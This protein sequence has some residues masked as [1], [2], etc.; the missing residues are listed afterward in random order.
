MARSF[1][2]APVLLSEQIRNYDTSNGIQYNQFARYN[3]GLLIHCEVSKRKNAV[4]HC[5]TAYCPTEKVGMVRFELLLII[6]FVATPR[7]NILLAV[8]A[9]ARRHACLRQPP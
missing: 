6:L 3:N 2:V 7:L 5:P 9:F 1:A 4:V 8:I